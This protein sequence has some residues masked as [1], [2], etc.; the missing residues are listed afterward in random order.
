MKRDP[1]ISDISLFRKMRTVHCHSIGEGTIE[2]I[3]LANLVPGALQACRGRA[4]DAL[5]ELMKGDPTIN[6]VPL[7]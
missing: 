1:T 5:R 6:D 2:N 4:N 3:D 7:C